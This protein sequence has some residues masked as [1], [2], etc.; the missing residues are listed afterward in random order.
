LHLDGPGANDVDVD[1]F[2]PAVSDTADSV[3]A[4]KFSDK[5]LTAR[6]IRAMSI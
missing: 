5:T 4:F 6:Q 3:E 1:N 2:F